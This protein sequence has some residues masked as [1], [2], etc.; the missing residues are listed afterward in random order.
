MSLYIVLCIKYTNKICLNQHQIVKQLGSRS[1]P[2]IYVQTVCKGYKQEVLHAL[3]SKEFIPKMDNGNNFVQGKP[4]SSHGLSYLLNLHSAK[5][6]IRHL[7]FTLM[8]L[9]ANAIS[10]PI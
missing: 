7:H 5:E 2:L 1:G 8:L 3:S 4:M 6:T 10:K 9:Y